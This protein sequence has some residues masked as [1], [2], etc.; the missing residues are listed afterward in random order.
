MWDSENVKEAEAFQGTFK[1][2]KRKKKT[3]ST[4]KIIQEVKSWEEASVFQ[5]WNLG[6][7]WEVHNLKDV[8]QKFLL[9]YNIQQFMAVS[10][11]VFVD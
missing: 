11:V 5:Q 9:P 6:K 10:E 8:L 3:S 4:P 7:V 2:W 1:I